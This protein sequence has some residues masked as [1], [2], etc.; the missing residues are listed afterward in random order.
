MSLI[1]CLSCL[2][3][4]TN[5]R[6]I[7]S[8]T[9][10]CFIH[11]I[12]QTLTPVLSVAMKWRQKHWMA[13]VMRNVTHWPRNQPITSKNLKTPWMTSSTP[14]GPHHTKWPQALKVALVAP[15][16]QILWLSL[17]CSR[18]LIQKIPK[19]ATINVNQLRPGKSW[20]VRWKTFQLNWL[21]MPWRN[22]PAINSWKS[23]SIWI[24]W[25][26]ISWLHWKLNVHFRQPRTM[27]HSRTIDNSY[28][29]LLLLLFF[30]FLASVCCYYFLFYSSATW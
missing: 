15:R 18:I 2:A 8:M 19:T 1:G 25:C 14:P 22:C 10:C 26:L 7:D 5:W 30:C 29:F 28:N 9:H 16:A 3:I 17:L 27:T 21:L 23:T 4:L 20:F 6:G 11:F 12:F 13:V 24:Q